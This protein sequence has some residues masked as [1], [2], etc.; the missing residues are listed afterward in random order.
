MWGF[1]LLLFVHTL[2][3]VYL[4]FVLIPLLQYNRIFWGREACL[5]KG[6]EEDGRPI[7]GKEGYK[8]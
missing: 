2:R 5:D 3:K 6:M 1:K 8:F 4:L 7:W